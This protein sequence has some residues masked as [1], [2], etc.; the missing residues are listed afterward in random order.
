[1]RYKDS[2]EEVIWIERMENN[3]T[4]KEIADKLDITIYKVKKVINE[5]LEGKRQRKKKRRNKKSNM[6]K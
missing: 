3:K 6:D 4:Y 2:V 5:R 1:M